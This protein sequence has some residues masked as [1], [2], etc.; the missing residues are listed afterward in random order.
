MASPLRV[1]NRGLSQ[2][3]SDQADVLISTAGGRLRLRL[4]EFRDGWTAPTPKQLK[5]R[6]PAAY[7]ISLLIVGAFAGAA[8]KPLLKAALDAVVGY[9]FSR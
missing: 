8:A 3:A 5:D 1:G 4:A 6:H 9:S 2:A 7:A